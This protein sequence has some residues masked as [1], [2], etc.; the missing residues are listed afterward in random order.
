[1]IIWVQKVFLQNSLVKYLI[2]LAKT[3]VLIALKQDR[4][5]ERTLQEE[6]KPGREVLTGTAIMFGE[7]FLLKVPES[8]TH[9]NLPITGE[10]SRLHHGRPLRPWCPVCQ[11]NHLPIKA[12]HPLVST[13][14]HR[15]HYDSFPREGAYH[16]NS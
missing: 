15:S 9:P 11:E 8:L 14:L 16:T 3:L 1:M 12:W 13:R 6:A 10:D 5:D 4:E 2:T 7:A